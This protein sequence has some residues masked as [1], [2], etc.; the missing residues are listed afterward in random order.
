M[1]AATSRDR[2]GVALVAGGTITV[3][4]FVTAEAL[5]PGYSTSTQT[6]SALGSTRGTP[7]S[8]VVFNGT[9]IVAGVL[10]VLAAYELRKV[11]ARRFLTGILA[12]TGVG[13]IGVGVLPSQTGLP[14][15]LAAFLAFGGL[16]SGALAVAWQEVG[17]FRW[18]SAVLGTVELTA[19]VLF[20]TIGGG[21]P[22]GI[23]G[24]ERWVAYL[25]LVWAVAFGGYL[26]A[27]GGTRRS[28]FR[29]SGL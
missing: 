24:L 3:L 1:S 25:G 10:L 21:T 18:V 20:V 5:F 4:G 12:L 9:M 11:Y 16:G 6:I 17:P 13:I 28:G 7:G 8:R 14:H 27:A 29:R 23:G 2:A 15:F 22:L 19:L 26:L